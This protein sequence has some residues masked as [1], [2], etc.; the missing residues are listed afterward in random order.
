MRLRSMQSICPKWRKKREDESCSDAAREQY[1]LS[2]FWIENCHFWIFG[3][4]FSANVL[5]LDSVGIVNVS[6][7]RGGR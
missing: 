3:T 6:I 5:S 2:R 7:N 1:F 4:N